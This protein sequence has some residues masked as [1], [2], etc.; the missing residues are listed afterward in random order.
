MSRTSIRTFLLTAKQHLQK[1][2][3]HRGSLSFVIGNESADL[4]SI[5]CAIL[6]GYLQSNDTTYQQHRHANGFVIPITNI[7]SSDLPLR[8]ELTA[9]LK[10]ADLKPS[11]LITLDDL[12]KP[13]L[14]LAATDWTLVDHNVLQGS[15]GECYRNEVIGVIDHH[16][17]EKIVSSMAKP[18]IIEKTGSCCSHVVNHCRTIWEKISSTPFDTVEA[19]PHD[20]S[21]IN[22]E[23]TNASTWDA[24]LAELA[25]GAILIDTVNLEAEQKV[26]DHDRKAVEYLE[27]KINASPKL[28]SAY[29]RKAFFE[30]I[31]NAKS[32]LDHLS[33]ED[34]LRKDYKQWTEGDLTLGISSAVQ[35]IDYL[36][37]KTRDLAKDLESFAKS[38][39]LQIYVVMTAFSS[40]EGGFSRQILLLSLHRGR[41][42]EVAKRF[43]ENSSKELGLSVHD[44]LRAV[45][46]DTEVNDV[47]FMKFWDQKNLAASRK[48]VGP[49]LREAMR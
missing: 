39:N 7:P 6:Y 29:R 9:L 3:Q 2:L 32:N 21:A 23:M 14:P 25:L 15:L 38:R 17:D 31:N 35:S 19:A 30:E 12:G 11:D 27:T 37:T 41:A 20:Q 33:L 22:D 18:R 34:I 42:E 49:M 28:S 45:T 8:P 36:K 16:D 43:E 13:P 10:H 24:Q 4:D 1:G 26:T 5:M 46:K 47:S 48:R 40:E 44:E